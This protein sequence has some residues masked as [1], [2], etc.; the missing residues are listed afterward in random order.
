[1]IMW[2]DTASSLGTTTELKFEVKS[3]N[4]KM[5]PDAFSNFWVFEHRVTRLEEIIAMGATE[6]HKVYIH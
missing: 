1:M 5:T 6:C 3:I 4:P 2:Q